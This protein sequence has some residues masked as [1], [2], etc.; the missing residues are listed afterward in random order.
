MYESS[1]VQHF[2]ERGIQQGIQQGLQQGIQQGRILAILDLI[3]ERFSPNDAERLKPTLES[4]A[5]VDLLRQVLVKASEAKTVSEFQGALDAL[6]SV[7]LSSV[8]RVFD[9]SKSSMSKENE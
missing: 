3:S 2:T 4:I 9:L 1:I 7:G 8:P 5:D 6:I